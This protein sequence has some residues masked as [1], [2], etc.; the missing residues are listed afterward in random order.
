MRFRVGR[1]ASASIVAMVAVVAC[2][3][4]AKAT[5]AEQTKALAE[6]AAAHIQ[7]V[8]KEKAFADFNRRDGGFIDGDLYVFCYDSKGVILA[9]GNP[10]FMGRNMQRLKDPDGNEP[11]QLFNRKVREE[12]RG[13][14]DYKWPN[15]V[16]KRIDDKSSYVIGIDDVVCGAGYYKR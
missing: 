7:E 8:G 14:V 12:G 11:L 16:T 9:H 5:T 13:W 15:P 6:R 4:A 2:P 3:V 10:A 1:S